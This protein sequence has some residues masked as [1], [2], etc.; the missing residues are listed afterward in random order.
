MLRRLFPGLLWLGL[1][2]ALTIVAWR[3]NLQTLL[4]QALAWIEGLGPWGPPAFIAVYVLACVLFVPGSLLTLGIGAIYGL[5][6][7]TVYV[8]LAAT[9]G[10]TTAFLIGR[11]LARDWV[12]RKIGGNQGFA[13]LDQAIAKEGW[14]IVLLARLSPAFPF[15]LLN[16]GLGL[17][18]VPLRDYV[19]ASWA[20]MLPG[21]VLY[22][23][24]G[25]LAGDLAGLGSRRQARGPAEWAFYGLGLA[26]TV[27]VT[28]YVTRLA[29]RALRQGGAR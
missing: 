6:W 28:L 8:S 19:L 11:H 27:A 15:N 7:G 1:A 16:Y 25:S 9:T 18:R 22:V 29:R 26:A 10:A 21:T 20:G 3:W 14:K 4:R 23:Y 13:A 5:A 12:T 24:L 17:T 2:A